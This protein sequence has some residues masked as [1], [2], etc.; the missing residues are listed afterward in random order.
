MAVVSLPLLLTACYEHGTNKPQLR[1]GAPPVPI[2]LKKCVNKVLPKPDRER[3]IK[4]PKYLAT[5]VVKLQRS[6]LSKTYCGRRLIAMIE[7]LQ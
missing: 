6:D 2:E 7:A 1:H 5:L 4:D 3:L